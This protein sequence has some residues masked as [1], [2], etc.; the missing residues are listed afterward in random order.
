VN[1][2]YRTEGECLQVPIT[3]QR[4]GFNANYYEESDST[5]K[6]MLPLSSYTDIIL[7]GVPSEIDDKQD[8][9]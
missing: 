3:L 7:G 6:S 1:F 2:E 4:L 9:E 8:R 5:T